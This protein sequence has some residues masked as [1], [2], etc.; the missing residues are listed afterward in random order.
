MILSEFKS[1]NIQHLNPET[2]ATIAQM[3]EPEIK[4]L[5]DFV[6]FLAWKKSQESIEP[7]PPP[8]H[9]ALVPSVP[10][11]MTLASTSPP[12]LTQDNW[13]KALDM[14]TKERLSQLRTLHHR[15]NYP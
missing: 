8:E 13:H 6:Q 15:L 2:L 1:M 5:E 3:S 12:A 7:S 9:S 11:S 4:E 10:G 14:L